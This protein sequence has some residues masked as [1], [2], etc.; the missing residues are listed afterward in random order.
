MKKQNIKKITEAQSGYFKLRK[1]TL[2]YKKNIRLFYHCMIL[3]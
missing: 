2:G 1:H 3:L